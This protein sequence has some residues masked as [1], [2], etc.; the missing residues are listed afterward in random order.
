VLHT[1]MHSS[2]Q[3]GPGLTI[4]KFGLNEVNRRGFCPSSFLVTGNSFTHLREFELALSVAFYLIF[5]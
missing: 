5:V 1:H 3:L 4:P 2:A